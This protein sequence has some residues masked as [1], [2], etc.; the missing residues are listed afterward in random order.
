M[1]AT[2]NIPEN[3]A[4]TD[5]QDLVKEHYAPEAQ[6]KRI[7]ETVRFVFTHCSTVYAQKKTTFSGLWDYVDL[8]KKHVKIFKR[9]LKKVLSNST[10][11]NVKIRYNV[12]DSEIVIEWE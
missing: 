2:T 5:W 6:Q 9:N 4:L 1:R 7:T 11:K 3:M 12:E 10:F 8:D